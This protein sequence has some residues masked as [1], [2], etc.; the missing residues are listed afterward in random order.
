[1]TQVLWE[2]RE[3]PLDKGGHGVEFYVSNPHT[4]G[5]LV[6]FLPG[7]DW[8]DS[9]LETVTTQIKKP[10]AT[11]DAGC[12]ATVKNEIGEKLRDGTLEHGPISSSLFAWFNA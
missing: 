9:D 11:H 5:D 6:A 4:E 2:K 10:D 3:L 12:L 7:Y 1:M 8:L